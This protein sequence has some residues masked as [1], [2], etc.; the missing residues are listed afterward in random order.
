[1]K[2]SSPAVFL[3]RD[4]TLIED[5]GAVTDEAQIELYEWTIDAL[6]RLRE[7]GFKLFVVSNQDKVAGGE[8]TMAE[9]ERIHRWLDEFFCQHGI[10]I[11]RWYVCP[12]GPGAGCQ[13]RKPS[14]FF[15]HQA[16]E[17]FHLDLSRSFMIGD[18]AADVRAGRAAGACGLYLLTGHGIRH[19]TSVPDDFLVFRHL[20]DAVDWILKYP[21]GMVSLQQ[22]IAEAAA[23]IRNGKLV[24]FPTETVYGLGADAFN[25]T[26]VADI[27]AAKQRPLAD[28]LIVHIADR[29]QLDDLVQALPAVAERLC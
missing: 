16:A 15:L 9:V 3:D 24:V 19:L 11:T 22:A 27:F 4:G 14:P 29:A 10:E 1:M 26:A 8:L 21:R 2:E 13:C 12:H 28:P 17:E 23:C 25:A 20:G 5:I 6:R 18:H 7:A